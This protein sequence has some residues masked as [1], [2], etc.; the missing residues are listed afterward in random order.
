MWRK[1]NIVKKEMTV[2][3]NTLFQYLYFLHHS[4]HFI[5]KRSNERSTH[6]TNSFEQMFFVE[7]QQEFNHTMSRGGKFE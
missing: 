7:D 5:K 4:R 1:T 2:Y 3:T 6:E